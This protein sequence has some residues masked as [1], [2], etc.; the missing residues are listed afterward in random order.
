[1]IFNKNLM[2]NNNLNKKKLNICFRVDGNENIGLGHVYR[3][4][5]LANEFNIRHHSVFFLIREDNAVQD[6]LDKNGY[7]ITTIKKTLSLI[8]EI[9]YLN[10][11][12]N[13]NQIDIIVMDLY[14]ADQKY[15]RYINKV[16]RLLV[17]IDVLHDMTLD[18]DIIIN[19]GIYAV[20]SFDLSKNRNKTILLGPQYNLVRSQFKNF[21]NKVINNSVKNI[22]IT[23]GGSDVNNLTYDIVVALL[24]I[25]KSINYHI[26]FGKASK[27]D[28]KINKIV[29][30]NK[31]IHI[32][33]NVEDMATLMERNDIAIS[34]CGTTL[35]ELS[36]T[37]IPTIGIIQAKNQ[38][39][40]AKRFEQEGIIILFE[41]DIIKDKDQFKDIVVFLINNNKLRRNMS[42]KG[43]KLINGE[44]AQNCYNKVIS[45]LNSKKF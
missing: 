15:I 7:K 43:Q 13:N 22:L 8:D 10:S 34:A 19:G 17:V 20:N 38:I 28:S 37:G 41:G 45:I 23:I 1:M 39:I 4:M 32:Y 29:K 9:E 35:Y 11:F 14:I 5:S 12:L 30:M 21:P 33:H 26:V 2:K 25:D 27:N 36:A 6:I 24:E 44:G 40:Q 42:I 16:N 31:K 3:T 18:V